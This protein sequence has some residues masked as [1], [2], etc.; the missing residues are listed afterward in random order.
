M[1]YTI[2]LTP[3]DIHDAPIPR[4]YD[5]ASPAAALDA[6]AQDEGYDL[7]DGWP[8]APRG[9]VTVVAGGKIVLK[10]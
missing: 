8:D 1:T 7:W 6:W 10:C 5:A 3:S 2:H 9:E 4:A